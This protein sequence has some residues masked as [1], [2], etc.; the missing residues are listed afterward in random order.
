MNTSQSQSTLS[1]RYKYAPST[2]ASL[3]RSTPH[4]SDPSLSGLSSMEQLTGKGQLFPG[5]NNFQIY[6]S[7]D[8]ILSSESSQS[9]RQQFL[10]GDSIDEC[11]AGDFSELTGDESIAV[12]S[13]ADCEDSRDSFHLN[14]TVRELIDTERIYVKDLR[15]VVFVSLADLKYFKV[16]TVLFQ[17]FTK[18]YGV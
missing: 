6:R 13:E 4:A 2:H 9:D 12:R 3:M 18:L 8:S 11:D 14:M 10:D 5:L 1:D 15:D 17:I 16:F 7:Q